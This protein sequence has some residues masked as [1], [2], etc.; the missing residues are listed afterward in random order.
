MPDNLMPN[1]TITNSIVKQ[2][3]DIG[4]LRGGQLG[5]EE[6]RRVRDSWA[7]DRWDAHRD[8]ELAVA[9]EKTGAANSLATEKIGAAV[10]DRVNQTSFALAL[11]AAIGDLRRDVQVGFNQSRTD[12][13]QFAAQARTDAIQFN[14]AT[15]LAIEKTA[16]AGI[17]LATQ[18]HAA[19]Q[20]ALA[21]CC[22]QMKLEFAALENRTLA[23]EVAA[24]SAGSQTSLLQQILAAVVTGK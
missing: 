7:E 21:E 2:G 10:T 20:A 9:I 11:Q 17:L 13:I 16:A 14:A 19:A 12:A 1:D 18:N 22:C 8:T 5:Y 24:A 3:A 6:A 23:R 4:H 15:N